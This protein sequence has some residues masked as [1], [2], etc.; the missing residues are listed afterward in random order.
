MRVSCE[1]ARGTAYSVHLCVQDRLAAREVG[2]CVYVLPL[3]NWERSPTERGLALRCTDTEGGGRGKLSLCTCGALLLLGWGGGWA[4][5]GKSLVI[6][7]LPK[8]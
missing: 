3:Q 1:H 6:Y 2:W 7:K 8:K 4:R 5:K